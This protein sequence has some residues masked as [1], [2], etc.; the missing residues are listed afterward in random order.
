VGS[1][2]GRNLQGLVLRTS[3]EPEDPTRSVARLPR[4]SLVTASAMSPF[5]GTLR[6]TKKGALVATRALT[7]VARSQAKERSTGLIHGALSRG[8]VGQLVAALG[9]SV[10]LANSMLA[11]TP[12]RTNPMAIQRNPA[13]PADSP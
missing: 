7:N 13:H 11:V 4:P 6:E 9:R 5:N 12:D 2:I 10:V 3:G 8:K 1:A